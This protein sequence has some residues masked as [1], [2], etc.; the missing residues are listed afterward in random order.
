MKEIS[1][2]LSKEL[3]HS[4]V[5]YSHIDFDGTYIHLSEVYMG[6]GIVVGDSILE[7]I[8][9]AKRKFFEKQIA[10]ARKGEIVH[11]FT[12]TRNR[13]EEIDKWEMWLQP[14]YSADGNSIEYIEVFSRNLNAGTENFISSLFKNFYTA[15]D[16]D[17]YILNDELY[18]L[19]INKSSKNSDIGKSFSEIMERDDDYLFF[20]NT[21]EQA[22]RLNGVALKV[23]HPIRKSNRNQKR[24]CRISVTYMII[25][26]VGRY[27]LQI[28]DVHQEHSNRLALK[29]QE[30]QFEEFERWRSLGQMSAGI[31]HEINNPL[32]I[33]RI[34][35]E[36][37]LDR[38]GSQRNDIDPSHLKKLDSIVKQVDRIEN[39]ANSLKIY[40]RSSNSISK[41]THY[42][43]DLINDT[44][45]LFQAQTGREI[46]ID[47]KNNYKELEI[48]CKKNEFYQVILNL[49]MNSYQ[50][51]QKFN[52]LENCWIKIWIEKT[53]LNQYVIYIQDGGNGIKNE[54]VKDIFTPFFTTKDVGSG[55]GLGLSISKKLALENG[56]ILD[57]EKDFNYTTFSI[58]LGLDITKP[59]E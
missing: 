1:N 45:G 47:Y 49:L 52:S 16:D 48:E 34:Q 36:Q 9:P 17:L 59:S 2:N 44:L 15:T 58:T 23:T 20:L 8:I 41:Q 27:M 51:V 28:R 33:I 19:D 53:I 25:Q 42:L 11:F 7:T 46:Y 50:A 24:Y 40:S 31:A 54:V 10:E 56:M 6:Y 32:C 18:I 43:D 13:L 30:K 26:G 39:I 35:A 4:D 38:L 21:F 5:F 12:E 57:F 55:T 37:L 29:I 14:S 22:K 3:F